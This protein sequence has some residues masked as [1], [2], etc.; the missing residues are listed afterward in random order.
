[1]RAQLR[2]ALIVFLATVT[3]A[4]FY[5]AGRITINLS[6]ALASQSKTI[7]NILVVSVCSLRTDLLEAYGH[8][9]ESIMPQTDKFIDSSQFLFERA[10]NGY[11]WLSVTA[12]F[13]DQFQR[14][15]SAGY[16]SAGSWG[17]LP[18][19]RIP[20]LKSLQDP[21]LE[22]INDNDYE[23]DYKG[24][25][26]VVRSSVLAPRLKPFFLLTHIKYM[27]FPLIDRFNSDSEWDHYLSA[28][29]KMRVADYMAH[30]E[31]YYD[32]L[33]LLLMLTNNPE[34]AF[35][36][37]KVQN[38][39]L[40]RDAK[41]KRAV[42]GLV[43]N[44]EFLEAWKKSANFAEDLQILRLVYRANAR[45]MD[46]EILGPVLNLFGDK[47][48]QK[49]TV[50]VFVG[51]H[52]ETHMERDQLTHATSPYDE[53]VQIPLAVHYPTSWTRLKK[54]ENQV[55]LGNVPEV[56]AR[57]AERTIEPSDFS[58]ELLRADN[59]AVP[60]R[61]CAARMR[62]LRVEG[63]YKYVFYPES[64]ERRLYDLKS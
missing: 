62:G 36:H 26:H 25:L 6:Q 29:Q 44:A 24:F 30:P 61:D 55:Y 20:M 16:A 42:T 17:A 4:T 8:E 56:L 52:G 43:N 41:A 59:T 2:W 19:T 23:K 48:K 63:R 18:F 34:F 38:L 46:R 51:D 50:V 45:Y 57:L 28:A 54:I 3:V 40:G 14:I 64:G 35:A 22:E 58:K 37:P 9:G 32:K 33:P 49:N 47:E 27:H 15:L 39:K 21:K 11:T 12:Y 60:I 7:P 10:Y 31:V 1:M 13:T 53:A 5:R